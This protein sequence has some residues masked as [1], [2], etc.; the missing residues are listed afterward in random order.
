MGEDACLAAKSVIFQAKEKAHNTTILITMCKIY[1]VNNTKTADICL[2]RK[3]ENSTKFDF[4]MGTVLEIF[5][6]FR[7]DN[8]PV[9]P[10]T[11]T[12]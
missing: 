1:Y 12:I 8:A 9:P 11:L 3:N 2:K 4:R 7:T 5:S 6:F 10:P